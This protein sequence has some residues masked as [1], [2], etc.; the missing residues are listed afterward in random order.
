MLLLYSCI[1]LLMHLHVRCFEGSVCISNTLI[2]LYIQKEIPSVLVKVCFAY[3]LHGV[4]EIQCQQSN[5]VM[6][7]ASLHI[8]LML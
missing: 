3:T 6:E 2:E 1:V 4:M 8:H 5:A 7:I